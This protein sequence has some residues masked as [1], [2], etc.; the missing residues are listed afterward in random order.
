MNHEESGWFAREEK[1]SLCFS[2]PH[3]AALGCQQFS[4]G[5]GQDARC[6]SSIL[7]AVKTP[8]TG[9]TAPDPG[10]ELQSLKVRISC[11]RMAEAP[12]IYETQRLLAEYLLFHYG[13]PRDTTDW[14]WIPEEA[15]GFAQRTVTAL[16]PTSP[17]TFQRALDL[18]C[19]VGRSSF[20]LSG[21]CAEVLGIDFSRLF[22]ETAQRLH[23]GEVISYQRHEEGRMVSNR[24]AAAPPAARRE[25]LRFEC[26]DAMNLREDLGHFDL[27]HAANLLCRLPQPQR[28]LERLPHLVR[29][30]GWLLL[31]TP[32]TWLAEFT[33]QENWPAGSTF[34]WLQQRLVPHFDLEARVDLPFVI[35]EHARK[36]QFSVAL[37]T[38]WR[39][40]ADG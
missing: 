3:C 30:G 11:R 5:G 33:P 18:G 27:V 7:C 38:R 28:L 15:L 25:N 4:G 36:F 23:R 14:P 24:T 8:S 40:T 10:D 1:C 19:A 32:C 37:G 13:A 22:V 29:P 6:K 16:L 20:E 17:A 35:R 2:M 26:G 39:R 34:D 21:C 9:T 31:A 12:N